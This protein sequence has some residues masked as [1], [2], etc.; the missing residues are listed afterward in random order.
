MLPNSIQCSQRE[1][2]CVP[3]LETRNGGRRPVSRGL[4]KRDYLGAQRLDIDDIQ[5][6]HVNARPCAARRRSLK[7]T[8]RRAFGRVINSHVV[9]RLKETHLPDLLR[10]DSRSG[11]VR[12][13]S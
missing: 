3:A 13:S 11:Y 7:A 2:Q 8:N 1:A 4:Q 5:M 9:V 12:Y 6:L 10:A